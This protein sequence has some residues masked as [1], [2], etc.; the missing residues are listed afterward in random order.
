[1]IKNI[2]DVRPN[3]VTRIGVMGSASG[4]IMRNKKAVQRARDVGKYIALGGCT[5]VNG[6]CPGLPDEA[7]MGAKKAGGRTFGVSP[8]ISIRSHI[9]KYKSPVQ[10][11]DQFMFTGLGLMERDI[12]N[13]R[14]CNGIIILPGGTGTLNEFTV[15]YDEGKPIGILTGCGG[16]AE[17]IDKILGYCHRKVT[18][19]M[20]FSE[21]PE[22]LVQKLLKTVKN[23]TVS[24]FLDDYLVGTGGIV[25]QIEW[26]IDQ[27]PEMQLKLEI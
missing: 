14:S 20:V 24:A 13:I 9:E 12:L 19:R 15:A 6:A 3:I 17:H 18:D 5:L 23:T 4:E 1:M 22:E 25:D 26:T 21:D 16:V 2:F 10:H 7:A 11:Y 8:A 27:I